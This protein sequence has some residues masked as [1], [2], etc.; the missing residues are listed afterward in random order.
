VGELNKMDNN[1]LENNYDINEELE[2]PIVSGYETIEYLKGNYS[3]EE[4][5]E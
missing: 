4:M 1:H 2:I 5:S 3:I